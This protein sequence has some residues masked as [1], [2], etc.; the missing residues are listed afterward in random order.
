MHFSQS[1]FSLILLA[2][3]GVGL[4]LL[5]GNLVV[6][7]QQNKMIKALEAQ[8]R[9]KQQLYDENAAKMANRETDE[10][11]RDELRA[12]LATLDQHLADYQYM[13]TYLKQMKVIA[14][15]TDNHLR[16]IQPG[17]MRPLEWGKSPLTSDLTA[18]AV[19]APAAPD[20]PPAIQDK[21]RVMPINLEVQGDYVSLIN[22][23][24]QFR[25][26]RKL[27]YVRTID[28]APLGEKV[29]ADKLNIRMQTYA[30]ITEEQYAKEAKTVLPAEE[31]ME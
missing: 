13:P 20:A 17:D 22:L 3:V 18:P 31:V 9:Q 16:M 1:R 19:A 26:F 24:D 10:E 27:I 4:L 23:L 21:Y 29:G 14:G 8:Q 6:L 12:R 25:Q 28:L 5:I 15:L 11:T 30:I 7:Q 2:I